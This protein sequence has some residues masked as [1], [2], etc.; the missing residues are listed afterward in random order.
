MSTFDKFYCAL[1]QLPSRYPALTVRIRAIQK[2]LGRICDGRELPIE[3][4]GRRLGGKRTRV[5][6]FGLLQDLRLVGGLVAGAGLGGWLGYS[7][8]WER[9]LGIG[10]AV[11]SLL[12][13]LPLAAIGYCIAAAAVRRQGAGEEKVP[14]AEHGAASDR[15]DK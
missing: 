4:F 1:S 14:A 12:L 15:G 3:H 13:F 7:L 9:A 8:A 5:R 11:M 2:H 10:P 6:D